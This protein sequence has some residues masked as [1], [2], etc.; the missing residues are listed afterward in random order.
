MYFLLLWKLLYFIKISLKFVRSDPVYNIP[1]LVQI[2]A[3]HHIG[4]K[5]LSEPVMAQFT[6]AYMW[7]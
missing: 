7:L 3:W 6:D 4:D 1:L 2:M 5:P